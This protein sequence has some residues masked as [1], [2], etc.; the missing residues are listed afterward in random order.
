M[1]NKIIT[2]NFSKN[3]FVDYTFIETHYD[4]HYTFQ[5]E[6]LPVIEY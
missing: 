5:I 3:R 4:G 1:L 6:T 2:I